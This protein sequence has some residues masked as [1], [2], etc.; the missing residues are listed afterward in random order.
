M[1]GKQSSLCLD[2]KIHLR[3]KQL[4]SL[5]RELAV[6][7]ILSTEQN[8]RIKTRLTT[9]PENESFL[10]H[11]SNAHTDSSPDSKLGALS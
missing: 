1:T 5:E 8:T 4:P 3:R 7:F 10:P 6:T 9:A 11:S 2:Q